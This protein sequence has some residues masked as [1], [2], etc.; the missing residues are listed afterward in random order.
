MKSFFLITEFYEIFY[1][2]EYNDGLKKS[3]FKLVENIDITNIENYKK[4]VFVPSEIVFFSVSFPKNLKKDL[5]YL[6]I[7]NEAT[8]KMEQLALNPANYTYIYREY[9][10][11]S[12][13][14]LTDIYIYIYPKTSANYNINEEYFLVDFFVEL[15][16][17]KKKEDT[18][19]LIIP[20]KRYVVELFFD[21]NDLKNIRIAYIEDIEAEKNIVK[22][23][24]YEEFQKEVAD[25]NIFR[26]D[27]EFDKYVEFLNIKQKCDIVEDKILSFLFCYHKNIKPLNVKD[28]VALFINSSDIKKVILLIMFINIILAAGSGY[29]FYEF[30]E[31]NKI[32][33]EK[34]EKLDEIEQKLTS[35]SKK[36]A[37]I[38]RFINSELNKNLK[39]L[40][41]PVIIEFLYELKTFC[42][43]NNIKILNMQSVK[44]KKEIFLKIYLKGMDTEK[45]KSFFSK[46][47]LVDNFETENIYFVDKE[48]IIILKVSLKKVSYG[49]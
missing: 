15:L 33:K 7:E 22:Q 10:N 8:Q 36:D 1:G 21:N 37:V 25:K 44:K 17:K 14:N 28:K 45:I 18:H 47:M 4:C 46:N 3:N 40:K 31:A 20:L 16:K 32:L 11:V 39:K 48:K 23:I 9:K 29:Y 41:I 6:Q 2:I 34:Y 35:L 42:L 27:T 43:K 38:K 12:K 5:K 30:N 49:Y 24:N 19:I 13:K 26:L